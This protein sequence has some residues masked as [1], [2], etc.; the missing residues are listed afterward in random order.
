LALQVKAYFLSY[1]NERL[2]NIQHKAPIAGG[3]SVNNQILRQAIECLVYEV[4][5]NCEPDGCTR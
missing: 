1:S 4:L 2:G 5:L 3:Y